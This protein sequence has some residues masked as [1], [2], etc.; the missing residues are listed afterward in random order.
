MVF[1]L[2]GLVRGVFLR[3][4]AADVPFSSGHLGG[5]PAAAHPFLQRGSGTVTREGYPV[6]RDS[7]RH[8]SFPLSKAE[9]THATWGK[10]KKS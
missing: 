3:A 6:D 9:F 5:L 1:S 4:A 10:N 8:Y 7:I 2:S